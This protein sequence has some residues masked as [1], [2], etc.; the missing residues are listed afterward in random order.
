MKLQQP[1]IKQHGYDNCLDA[2]LRDAH[3]E[4]DTPHSPEPDMYS[5][6]SFVAPYNPLAKQ[7]FRKIK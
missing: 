2:T 5:L 3:D 7:L 6:N 4:K 1:Q